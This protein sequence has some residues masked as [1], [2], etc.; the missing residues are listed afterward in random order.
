MSATVYN[1]K[2][3]SCGTVEIPSRFQDTRVDAHLL[4]EVVVA[5]LA[6]RRSGTSDTK[7][8]GEVRGGGKK[9]W[10]QKG[11]GRAR[12]GSIRSPLWRKGGIIFGPHPRSYEQFLTKKKYALALN[13]ALSSK[14]SSGA[15]TVLDSLDA[16]EGKT[17]NLVGLMA[18]LELPQ[19]TLIV[20]QA[21]SDKLWRA[22]RN[23]P[24]VK[25]TTLADL[26]PYEVIRHKRLVITQEA[27]KGL[28]KI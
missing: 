5:Q 16:A 12:S 18:K 25:V 22:V 8:R 2:G 13:Q 24:H 7:T 19:G 21:V 6:N 14:F 15:Y 28:E 20:T 27:L 26:N 11:T 1:W 10:K 17:K 4:H 9:P 3:D 23:I